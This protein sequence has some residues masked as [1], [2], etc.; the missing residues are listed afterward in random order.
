MTEKSQ[1]AT[2]CGG[3]VRSQNAVDCK[4]V[5]G[6]FFLR[7]YKFSSEKRDLSDTHKGKATMARK[8]KVTS[9][10]AQIEAAR[11]SLGD[12]VPPM[13]VPLGD[14]D[15]PFFDA[16]IREY[17]KSE[18][19][20]HQLEIA[21]MMARTMKDLEENQRELRAEGYITTR[22]SNGTTVE[23]PRARVVKSLTGD[24]LS[25]R[26]SLGVHARAK[27]EPREAQRNTKILKEYE[28]DN[29]LED[30]LLARPH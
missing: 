17:A 22:P 9:K 24:L 26:R 15:L 20:D 30:D 6:V 23:N 1:L 25:L 13:T 28:A 4:P 2:K 5:G 8:T 11:K 7:K 27:A 12:I 21:A 10:E 18:W 14:D 29:V 19:S 3:V 16:V